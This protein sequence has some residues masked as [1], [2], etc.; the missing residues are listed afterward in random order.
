MDITNEYTP[1][2][3]DLVRRTG[4]ID[5]EAVTV[6]AVGEQV[7]LGRYKS[8]LEYAFSYGKGY[9]W[10]KVEPPPT[11]PERWINVYPSWVDAMAMAC[12]TKSEADSR[13]YGNR[14]AVIHLATDGTVTLHPTT[15]GAS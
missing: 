14:I 6:T 9:S 5:R 12:L 8:S 7:F 15:G 13:A 3:G 1:Q 10:V 2:V 4:W 11:Y